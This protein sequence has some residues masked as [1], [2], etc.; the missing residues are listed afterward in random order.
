[1]ASDSLD[2][3]HKRGGSKFTGRVGDIDP[4]ASEITSI[5]ADCLVERRGFEPMAI[6]VSR[7]RIEHFA[8]ESQRR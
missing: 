5:C 7:P 6:A 4:V 2:R 8:S 3:E 1:M